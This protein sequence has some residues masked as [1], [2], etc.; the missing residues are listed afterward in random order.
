MRNIHT[1][2][3]EQFELKALAKATSRQDKRNKAFISAC[4]A[5]RT[6]HL[7]NFSSPVHPFTQGV[8]GRSRG[9][10]WPTEPFLQTKFCRRV[11][12]IVQC[13]YFTSLRYCVLHWGAYVLS[14]VRKSR[15]CT[16]FQNT[17]SFD[18][19]RPLRMTWHRDRLDHLNYIFC[20]C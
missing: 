10:M 11:L 4:S 16:W 15:G 9:P 3:F 19:C 18:G 6:D 12:Q 8:R 17:V 14:I 5:D 2:G 1:T 13:N 7:Q 20:H